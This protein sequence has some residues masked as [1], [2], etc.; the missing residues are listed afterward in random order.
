MTSDQVRGGAIGQDGQHE[1]SAEQSRLPEPEPPPPDRHEQVRRRGQDEDLADFP[2]GGGGAEGEPRASEHPGPGGALPEQDDQTGHDQCFEQNIGH[3]AL[4]HLDLVAIEQYRCGGD[5]GQRAG[6]TAAHQQHVQG[7]RH[8]QAEQVLYR[9]HRVQVAHEQDRLQQDPVAHRV[10]AAGEVQVPDRVAEEQG[11]TV[12]GLGQDAQGQ[13]RREQH[14]QQPV[15]PQQ[16][17][18]APAGPAHGGQPP[19]GC[20]GHRHER[21]PANEDWLRFRAI[22]A[23]RAPDPAVTNPACSGWPAKLAC[24]GGCPLAYPGAAVPADREPGC[25]PAGRQPPP[26]R[27]GQP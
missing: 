24:P 4:F 17:A 12:R 18:P 8:A 22:G 6:N 13:A 14:R 1:G 23:A 25:C 3:D 9:G 11:G 19:G 5:R 7:D 20:R 21:H 2:D 16:R 15:P 26:G 10:L 27:A